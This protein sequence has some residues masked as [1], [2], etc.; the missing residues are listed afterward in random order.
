MYVSDISPSAEM[1]VYV[2][3]CAFSRISE[4]VN[5]CAEDVLKTQENPSSFVYFPHHHF[6]VKCAFC[7]VSC[8]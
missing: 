4:N 1:D 3:V 8:T 6:S 2:F 5:T 7:A